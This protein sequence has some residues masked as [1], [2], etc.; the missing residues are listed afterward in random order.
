MLTGQYVTH[1]KQWFGSP[2][3]GLGAKVGPFLVPTF[4]GDPLHSISPNC[5]KNILLLR[6]VSRSSPLAPENK[7]FGH[8]QFQVRAFVLYAKFIL[9]SAQH[10][11]GGG[12]AELSP[13][14]GSVAGETAL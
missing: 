13:K 8:I 9:A 1:H 12:S 2:Q 10:G 4:S 11:A 7:R 3:P 14:G 5:S 6:S